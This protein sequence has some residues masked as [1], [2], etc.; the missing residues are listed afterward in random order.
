MMKAPV[1]CLWMALGLAVFLVLPAQASEPPAGTSSPEMAAVQA[2][3]PAQE[4]LDFATLPVPEWMSGTVN[5]GECASHT[6][7]PAAQCNQYCRSLGQFVYSC[8]ADATTC[9]ML[10]CFC[11]DEWNS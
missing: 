5:C 3:S 2:E 7:N 9:E 8:D 10:F 6:P 11:T 1:R 4:P